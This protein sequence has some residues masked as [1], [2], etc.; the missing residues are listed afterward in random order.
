MACIRQ[1]F[2]FR[3]HILLI[4]Q[5]TYWQLL[6]STYRREHLVYFPV[7]V[8][9]SDWTDHSN[10]RSPNSV[11]QSFLSTQTT[12]LRRQQDIKDV[13]TPVPLHFLV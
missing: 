13:L 7:A 2:L 5:P 10:L 12:F 4:Y 3:T 9:T 1:S 6:P 8:L 11:K